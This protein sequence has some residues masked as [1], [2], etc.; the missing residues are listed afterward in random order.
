MR[1]RQLVDAALGFFRSEV[2][3]PRRDARRPRVRRVQRRLVPLPVA[4][5][6]DAKRARRRRDAERL[7]IAESAEGGEAAASGGDGG[8]NSW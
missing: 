8:L 4:R 5:G 1:K 2:G 3:G 7:V 6:L